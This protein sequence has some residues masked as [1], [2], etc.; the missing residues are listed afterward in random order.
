MAT[1]NGAQALGLDEE[2]GSLEPGKSADL[3]AVTF[4]DIRHQPCYDP[5]GQLVYVCGREGVSHVW[6]AGEK[7]LDHSRLIKIDESELLQKICLWKNSQAQNRAP[8]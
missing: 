4:H 3:C 5:V 6:K 1:L 7:M 8:I 2:I